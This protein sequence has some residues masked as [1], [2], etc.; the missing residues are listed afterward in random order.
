MVILSFTGAHT[1]SFKNYLLQFQVFR[2]LKLVRLSVRLEFKAHMRHEYLGE[3][4]Q[5]CLLSKQAMYFQTL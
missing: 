4:N 2:V 5:F 1:S 3:I